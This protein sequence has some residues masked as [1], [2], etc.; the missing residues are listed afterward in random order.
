MQV[1]DD[2]DFG[3]Q[4]LSPSYLEYYN[5]FYNCFKNI[6]KSTYF[7]YTFAEAIAQAC[8]N[9]L[10]YTDILNILNNISTIS[11]CNINSPNYRFMIL[12]KEL[13]YN[14]ISDIINFCNLQ[15][16]DIHSDLNNDIYWKSLDD[17]R[18]EILNGTVFKS[19]YDYL[20][21]KI[22]NLQFVTLEEIEENVSSWLGLLISTLNSKYSNIEQVLVPYPSH[23]YILSK[24]LILALEC[25]DTA[26]E[27]MKVFL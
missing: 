19:C 12:L 20:C 14:T 9:S 1:T 18:I 6:I 27:S 22:D 8:M 13:N 23:P 10:I 5:S 7:A 15:N 17:Q 3:G 25:I 16:N 2:I 26:K 4:L 24:R 21:N 11:I